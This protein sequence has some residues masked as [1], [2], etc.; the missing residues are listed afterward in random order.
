MPLITP[1]GGGSAPITV[2]LNASDAEPSTHPAHFFGFDFSRH[3]AA[4]FDGSGDEL[5]VERFDDVKSRGFLSRSL[6]GRGARIYKKYQPLNRLGSRLLPLFPG[7]INGFE[8]PYF[9]SD[10]LKQFFKSSE[11]N[12]LCLTVRFETLTTEQVLFSFSDAAGSTSPLL[13]LR[14]LPTGALQVD[15]STD[16]GSRSQESFL[17]GPALVGTERFETITLV[18]DWTAQHGVNSGTLAVYVGETQELLIQGVWPNSTGQPIMPVLNSASVRFGSDLADARPAA[19]IPSSWHGYRQAFSSTELTT[20]WKAIHR[21]EAFD[22]N[23]VY[24]LGDSNTAGYGVVPDP[25]D[26]NGGLGPYLDHQAERLHQQVIRLSNRYGIDLVKNRGQNGFT[27]AAMDAAMNEA[28]YP[29]AVGYGRVF[30]LMIGFNDIGGGATPAA[31]YTHLESIINKIKLGVDNPTVIVVTALPQDTSAKQVD[32]NAYNQLI[33]DGLT[34]QTLNADYLVDVA[35]I[36]D[37]GE[38]PFDSEAD[39]FN[40]TYYTDDEVHINATGTLLLAKAISDTYNTTVVR[41]DYR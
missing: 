25:E 11:G 21:Q 19:M 40:L 33:R 2:S 38:L 36:T 34:N 20:I 8:V 6:G 4:S 23:V 37:A 28:A 5:L 22:A 12:T 7:H 30:F 14:A 10:E 3:F 17:T 39:V 18:V 1:S 31:T 29:S 15:I 13:Q 35:A 26:P 41:Q 16:D 32:I 24:F 9:G 27:A